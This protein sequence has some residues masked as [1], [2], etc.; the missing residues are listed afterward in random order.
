MIRNAVILIVLLLSAFLAHGQ[1]MTLDSASI[2][3][4]IKKQLDK[5]A[6]RELGKIEKDEQ[7]ASDQLAD[8]NKNYGELAQKKQEIDNQKDGKIRERLLKKSL[9]FENKIVRDHVK[10][11]ENKGI[12]YSRRSEVYR[13]DIERIRS[14]SPKDSAEEIDELVKMAGECFEMA[15]LM[16]QKTLHT[17]NPVELF[18]IFNNAHNNKQLGILYQEKVYAIILNGSPA[19]KKGIDEKIKALRSKGAGRTSGKDENEDENG[20]GEENGD[21]NGKGKNNKQGKDSL[22]TITIIVHDT[23]KIGQIGE[24]SVLYK[25]QIAASKTAL[26]IQE[27]KK[28]YPGNHAIQCEIENNWYKYSVGYFFYYQEAKDFKI[29]S[30][31]KDAFIIAY[32]KEKKVPITELTNHP[33]YLKQL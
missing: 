21:Q 22:K 23:I 7:T 15:G 9:K 4:I 33:T 5:S 29:K 31:V 11:L 12:L 25:V 32:I 8:V 1:E 6:L 26:T 2:V 3:E 24:N 10:I 20:N 17:D 16:E 13:K 28:I 27:L 19:T 14:S 18:Q 30:G